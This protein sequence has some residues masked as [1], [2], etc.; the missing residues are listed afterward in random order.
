M[1]DINLIT[2][3]LKNW[4]KYYKLINVKNVSEVISIKNVI[5]SL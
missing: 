4:Q 3:I 5:D 2:N 1:T